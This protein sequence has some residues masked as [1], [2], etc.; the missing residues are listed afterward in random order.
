MFPMKW[1]PVK[2]K[3]LTQEK[4]TSHEKCHFAQTTPHSKASVTMLTIS[5]KKAPL[6]MAF[7]IT[8]DFAGECDFTENVMIILQLSS[9]KF[10]SWLREI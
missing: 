8:I 1:Q 4:G 2:Q 3:P 7:K 5:Q 10:M 6:D 9:I